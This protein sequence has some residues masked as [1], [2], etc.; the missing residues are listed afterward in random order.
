MPEHPLSRRRFVAAAGATGALVAVGLPDAAHA[1]GRPAGPAGPAG[2][3]RHAW[4]ARHFADP[5]HDSR[6]TVYWYWNGPVT[7]E[8]VDRQ[9]ADLR[10]KGMYE[11]ILFSFDNAEMTPVFFTEEWFD[12][13]GHVLRTAERTG[14]RVWLFNDDHF[15]S[16]RAGEFIVKGGQVGTR[17]YAPGP[18]CA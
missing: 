14:M 15:P 2:Q 18:T 1:S 3:E 7:P 12:I 17:T 8:L 9:L 4:S 6:P 11:V 16:G 13:V 5:R 10:S